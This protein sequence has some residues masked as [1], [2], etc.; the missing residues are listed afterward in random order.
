MLREKYYGD[1]PGEFSVED[2]AGYFNEQGTEGLPEWDESA[3]GPEPAEEEEEEEM[4]PE[5]MT[6]EYNEKAILHAEMTAAYQKKA[7]K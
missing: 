6:A 2:A 1:G 3:W 5:A 7:R 4:S